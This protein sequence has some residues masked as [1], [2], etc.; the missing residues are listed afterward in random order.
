VVP[1]FAD[2]PERPSGLLKPFARLVEHAGVERFD[3]GVLDLSAPGV[4]P[5]RLHL[6]DAMA[7]DPD[8]TDA[9]RDLKAWSDRLARF[10]QDHDRPPRVV[11]PSSI[12]HERGAPRPPR[13][14]DDDE[15]VDDAL[16][17]D[18]TRLGT[19]L[20]RVME[21]APLD[22]P[23]DIPETVRAVA[24]AEGADDGLSARALRMAEAAVGSEIVQQAVA[25]DGFHR[26]VP[27]CV[28]RDG[29]TVEGKIDL[30]FR[31]GGELAI[32]DYKTDAEPEGG[33]EALVERYRG[34]ALA[35]SVAAEAATGLDVRDVVLLFLSG[36]EPKEIR[37]PLGGTR[38]ERWSELERLAP[39]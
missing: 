1:W 21:R 33:F 6:D 24:R 18:G 35:Y 14:G 17:R 11:T 39:I 19:L 32:V 28:S 13:G 10:A 29:V 25:S 31:E 26:E 38:E 20:H 30:L 36:S 5:V 22:A 3:S 9:S 16:R 23:E 2:K 8:G 4:R 15:T 37:V 27:F 12:G 7:A 34:Q